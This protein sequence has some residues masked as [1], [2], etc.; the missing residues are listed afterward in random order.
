MGRPRKD[1]RLEQFKPTLI[2]KIIEE[3]QPSELVNLLVAYDK[4]VDIIKREKTHQIK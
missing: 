1:K 3:K 2:G 4:L